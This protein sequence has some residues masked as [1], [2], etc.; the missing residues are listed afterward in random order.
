MSLEVGEALRVLKRTNVRGDVVSSDGAAPSQAGPKQQRSKIIIPDQLDVARYA[1]RTLAEDVAAKHYYPLG[2]PRLHVVRHLDLNKIGPVGRYD[3]VAPLK[4]VILT[5]PTALAGA[6]DGS[7]NAKVRPR[8]NTHRAFQDHARLTREVL[9]RDATV[10][11]LIQP[12]Q[13]TEASFSTDVTTGVGKWIV[14]SSPLEGVRREELKAYSGGWRLDDD[15][16][17]DGP[18]EFGDTLQAWRDGVHYFIQGYNSMRGDTN[19]IE[20]VAAMIHAMRK[21]GANTVHVPV[22]LAGEDTLHI[23]Y[24]SNYAGEGAKRSMLVAPHAFADANDIERLMDIFEVPKG[25]LFVVGYEDML[26]GAANISCPNPREVFMGD[27]APTDAVADFFRSRG[28]E[29]VR[30]PFQHKKK[31]GRYHCAMGQAHRA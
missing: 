17:K 25:G 19:S 28:L 3:E 11:L 26:Q 13:A 5:M 30:L 18:V 15:G 12:W 6:F 24:A 22:K 14:V 1:H 31:D 9:K 20:R 2:H 16:R 27:D 7:P 10:Y 4:T 21:Q 23:D 8:I 29:I